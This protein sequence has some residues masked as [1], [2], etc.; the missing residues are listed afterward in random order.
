MSGQT[1][2][3]YLVDVIYIKKSRGKKPPVPHRVRN[4]SLVSRAKTIGHMNRNKDVI[5]SIADRMKLKNYL[6]LRVTN[7]VSQK[8]VGASAHYK[9]KNY[10]DEFK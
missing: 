6:S 8:E 3:Y 1:I 5:T 2:Y 9:D 4:I 7:I 10:S